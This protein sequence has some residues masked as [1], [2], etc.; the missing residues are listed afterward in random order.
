M[1]HQRDGLTFDIASTLNLSRVDRL[2]LHGSGFDTT[3][4]ELRRV[5]HEDKFARVVPWQDPG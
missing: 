5:G 2:D 4:T 3:V 1:P